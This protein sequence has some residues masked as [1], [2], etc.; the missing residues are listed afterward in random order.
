MDYASYVNAD[1]IIAYID[2]ADEVIPDLTKI[3]AEPIPL[4]T[5]G[6][7]ASGI[8]QISFI[9][10][11]Y[12]ELGNTIGTETV[13]GLNENG[14]AFIISSEYSSNITY[15][16]MTNSI[17]T[18]LKNYPG[19]SYEVVD[20][21]TLENKMNDILEVI[22]ENLRL[23]KNVIFVCLTEE[24]TIRTAQFL[25]EINILSDKHVNLIGF[26]N[27]ETCQGY[28]NK[29]TIKELI[30]LDPNSIGEAAI[31]ELFE[32]KRNGYANSYIAADVIIQKGINNE[33]RK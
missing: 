9:G 26:G 31:R 20:H 33:I 19:I 23:D 30:S 14:I 10:N 8:K 4:V 7:F 6:H 32:Y 12:W 21:V 24:D 25:T 11:N 1:G 2:S 29:G 16:N 22:K 17:Q 18:K 27:N 15:S 13:A 5:T 28:L 3:H